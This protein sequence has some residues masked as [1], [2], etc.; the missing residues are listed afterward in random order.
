MHSV[1][2]APRFGWGHDVYFGEVLNGPTNGHQN[3]DGTSYEVPAGG[4][5]THHLSCVNVLIALTLGPHGLAGSRNGFIVTHFE[6]LQLRDVSYVSRIFSESFR[7]QSHH[8]SNSVA[9]T[10]LRRHARRGTVIESD[11]WGA[12]TSGW[13]AL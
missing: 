11:C 12:V 9:R 1:N 3:C 10:M 4:V 7:R 8:A 5:M 2:Y 6:V 13:A